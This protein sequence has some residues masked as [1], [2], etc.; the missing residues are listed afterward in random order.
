[1]GEVI[2]I[3]ARGEGVTEDG[4][5]I[6]FAVP[7]DVVDAAG[8][9]TPGPHHAVPPCRHFPECGGCQLQHIDDETYANYLIERI[10]SA[11]TAQ[12]I[13]TDIRPPHLSP[14]RTRRRATLQAERRG[15]AV[16][17]GFN[18]A[19]SHRIVDRRG[20]AVLLAST[21]PVATAS[22]T[23]ANAIFFTQSCSRWLRRFAHC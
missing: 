4:R 13:T 16:L 10:G 19:A 20:K 8:V 23:C 6:A 17:L 7:G 9:V 15:K 2:R 14:P 22:S 11:L 12:G 21:R 1:M 18:E 5:F 3:A